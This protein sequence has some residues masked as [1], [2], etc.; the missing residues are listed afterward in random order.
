LK[1]REEI[2][3]CDT[4]NLAD[5]LPS[6][7]AWEDLFRETERSLSGYKRYEGHLADSG[8][9]LFSCL[10]FDEELSLKIETLFVYGKQKSDENTGNARYQ[11][12]SSRARS[13]S[14]EAAGLSSFLIPEILAIPEETLDRYRKNTTGLTRY[15][16]TLEII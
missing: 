2:P 5:I 11:E 10:K 15:D 9:M 8:E 4:W 3:V 16:R 13:L 14:Y 7:S 1:K 12:F 6:E